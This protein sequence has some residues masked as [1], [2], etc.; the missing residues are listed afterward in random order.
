MTQGTSSDHG[1]STEQSHGRSR[2][3]VTPPH[4]DGLL[5]APLGPHHQD[6]HP[7]GP[8]QSPGVFPRPPPMG[9]QM[10]EQGLVRSWVP[11]PGWRAALGRRLARSGPAPPQVAASPAG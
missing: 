8:E 4:P 10:S 1:D 9:G 7:P 6:P 5:N 11:K 2:L 3:P